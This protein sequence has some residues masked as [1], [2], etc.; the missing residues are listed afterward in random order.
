MSV[1]CKSSKISLKKKKERFIG[2]SLHSIS[3]D[4]SRICG[5]PLPFPF[6]DIQY[7]LAI[8]PP[9]LKITTWSHLKKTML[10]TP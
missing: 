9:G 8:S 10:N 7:V 1:S 4:I 2:Q 5:R 6:V 3:K